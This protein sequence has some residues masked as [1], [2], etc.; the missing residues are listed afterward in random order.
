MRFGPRLFV[1]L[2]S[3]SPWPKRWYHFYFAY[4]ALLPFCPELAMDAFESVKLSSDLPDRFWGGKA[5]SVL[6]YAY[7]PYLGWGL[8]RTP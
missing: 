3:Y 6:M 2:G 8:I 4:H 1:N 5:F 7:V